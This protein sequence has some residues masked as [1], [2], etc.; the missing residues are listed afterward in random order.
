VLFRRFGATGLPKGINASAWPD[1]ATFSTG[2]TLRVQDEYQV[3]N[4]DTKWSRILALLNEAR[5]GGP[6]TLHVN[7]ASGYTSGFLGIPSI[8][9]V[10]NNINP[11]LSTFFTANPSGRFG[12]I[13]MDFADAARCALIYQT[14]AP[15]GRAVH[16]PAYFTLINR[17]S[18]KAIDLVNGNTA[19]GAAIN[20]WTRDDTAP[21]QRWALAPT[22]NADHFR[23]TSW[24]SGK[25]AG[26]EGDSTAAAAKLLARDYTG[27]NPAQQFDLI[28]AGNGFFKIRNVN[29]GLILEV[30]SAGTTDNARIQQNTDTG[31]PHQQWRL[32]PWGDY[33]IRAST[34]KYVRVGNTG[35]SNGDPIVQS[36]WQNQLSFLWRMTGVTNG[37][38]KAASAGAPGRVISVQDAFTAAAADCR[39]LDYN[40]SNIGDQKLRITPKTNGLFKFHFAHSGMAWDIPGGN[41]AD[42]TPLEQFPDNTNPWQEF[43]LERLVGSAGPDALLIPSVS[44]DLESATA[45]LAWPSQTGYLYQAW[46]SENL[47][48]WHKLTKLPLPGNGS[49]LTI[50]APQMPERCFYRVSVTRSP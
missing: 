22:E 30:A 23:I 46:W 4:N 50:T 18:G 44:I 8:T 2:G 20:Q 45:T 37:H 27:N 10:S 33:F 49:P 26:I 35:H 7:F 25:C 5:Y 9:S 31:T 40:P 41:A 16:H 24:V 21:D 6:D 42:L 43:Q 36:A 11:R 17:N 28:D 13:L 12:T 32:Q 1:Q 48:T 3:S 14:N 34:G 29:S 19:N 38:L 15:A 47:T 39:L